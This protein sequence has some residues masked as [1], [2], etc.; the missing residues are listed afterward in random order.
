MQGMMAQD[1]CFLYFDRQFSPEY[2]TFCLFPPG[3]SLHRVSLRPTSTQRRAFE[4]HTNTRILLPAPFRAER[5][6]GRPDSFTLHDDYLHRDIG[7]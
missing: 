7:T 3:V 2:L 5:Y 6:N 4:N 1:S